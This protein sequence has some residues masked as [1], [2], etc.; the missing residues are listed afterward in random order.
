MSEILSVDAPSTIQLLI[1]IGIKIRSKSIDGEGICGR[2]DDVHSQ[3][4][5]QIEFAGGVVLEGAVVGRSV[6]VVV[7]LP[8][9]GGGGGSGER[10]LGLELLLLLKVAAQPVVRRRILLLLR[11]RM[12]RIVLLLVKCSC[13]WW[14]RRE[15]GI[16]CYWESRVLLML[17]LRWQLAEWWIACWGR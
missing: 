3:W 10:I 11:R 4:A 17:L 1:V 14:R 6:L 9:N 16:D 12:M 7:V 13:L 5:A 8:V 15:G 2:R